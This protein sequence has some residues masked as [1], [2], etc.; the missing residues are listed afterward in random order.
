VTT[1]MLQKQIKDLR[2]RLSNIVVKKDMSEEMLYEKIACL[3]KELRAKDDQIKMLQQYITNREQNVDELIE[4]LSVKDEK[5]E[6]LTAEIA[7][8][9][10]QRD[11]FKAMLSKDSA[12]SSKPP[13]TDGF[14]KA[15]ASSL[16]QRSGKK[17]GGQPGH[18]GRTIQFFRNPTKIIEKKPDAICPCGGM[19]QCGD[20]YTPK[21][22]ADIRV[23]LDVVEERVY[24][25]WCERCGKIHHGEFSEGFVNPVQYGSNV[26]TLIALLNG[27]ANVAV[28]KTVDILNGI[29]GGALSLSEG[30]VV[31]FQ[32]SLAQKIQPAIE[33]IKQRLIQ[34]NVLGADE[35][36][37]R[38][39][40]KLNWIQVFSNSQYT[41]FGLNKKRG[42]LYA[43][44]MDILDLF[45]GILVHDHFK[46]YYGYKLMTHAECNAHILRY[47]KAVIEIMKHPW[48][49]DLA[50]LLRETNKLKKHYLELGRNAME[51]NELNA[52]SARYDEILEAGKAQYAAA[53][54][55]KKNISYFNDE[56]L[57]LL[58]LKEYKPEHLRFLTNFD[59]PFDN[60]G[61]ERG[62]RF[63]KN[64]LKVAGCFRSEEGAQNYAKIASIVST[65]KKQGSNLY[66]SINDIF[67]GI[68]PSF[69][70]QY[71]ID[72]G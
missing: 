48:A 4:T 69:D 38:V 12:N 16:R 23:V 60:N 45:T 49:T 31:N 29:S 10:D 72:S 2:T 24:S 68:L 67:N 47:L 21:Q 41:L 63:F 61:S 43:D 25:G 22:V 36:G 37:C 34:C 13:S 35:T 7:A 58:R 39:N 28:N 51:E 59:V 42:D 55:N 54:E 46:S 56:R 50:E 1:A 30:T 27:Y 19:V 44:G 71:T 65:L 33:I 9:R 26:K 40:G 17:P 8:L 66:V 14:R 62:A 57:L 64:K 18:P 5:I 3:S 15:K 70:F 32:K 6:K 52:I 53:T 11:K 20:E